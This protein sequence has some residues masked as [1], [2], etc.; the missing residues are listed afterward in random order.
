L[1]VRGVFLQ[2]QCIIDREV[3]GIQQRSE[4]TLE[5]LT[6]SEFEVLADIALGMTDKAIA[7]RRR[8][9]TRSVQSRLKHLYEKL[10]I[11]TSQVNPEFGPVFNSRTRAIAIAFSRGLLNVDGLAANQESMDAWLNS[12]RP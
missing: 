1:A 4:D 12:K 5:G 2:D 7:A 9:S 10:C 11:D 8:I 6:D 3:R